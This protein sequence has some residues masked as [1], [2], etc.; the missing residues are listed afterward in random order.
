MPSHHPIFNG[1]LLKVPARMDIPLVIYRIG[2]ESD[3]RVGLDC[4][5]ANFLNIN[6]T[7][8]FVPDE[9]QSGVG[10]CIDARKDKRPLSEEHLEA[11]WMYIDRLMDI[12]CEDGPEAAQEE[13]TRECFEEWFED[14]KATEAENGKANWR[15]VAS[16]YDVG[17]DQEKKPVATARAAPPR[18]TIAP[19]RAAAPTRATPA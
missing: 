18:A 14:Y 1:P 16:I 10:S 11:V 15:N 13:M 19:K 4:R 2:I 12:F 8:G 3:N 9:W 7:T 5:I 17:K 6:Y